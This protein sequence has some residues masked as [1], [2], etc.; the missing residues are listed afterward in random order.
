[1]AAK[2][3]KPA[4]QRSRYDDYEVGKKMR[5]KCS[6]RSHA[7]LGAI[8]KKRDAVQILIDQGKDRLQFLLGLRY[9]RMSTSAFAF[10]RGAAAVMAADLSQTPSSGNLVRACGDAHLGNFGA[11]STPEHR[12]LFDVNDFDE[13]HPGPWEWDLKR[14]AASFVI[15]CQAAGY[16]NTDAEEV[17]R[18]TVKAYNKMCHKLGAMTILDAFASFEDYEELLCLLRDQKLELSAAKAIK[19]A[20]EK[21]KGIVEFQKLAHHVDGKPEIIDRPPG[22]FHPTSAQIP[23]FQTLVKRGIKQYIE[24]LPYARRVLMQRYELADLALKVVGVGSVGTLC[25]VALFFAD[26]DDPLFLQIKEAHASVL[27]KYIK[28]PDYKH[29]SHGERVVRSQLALQAAS[30]RFLGYFVD[31]QTKRHFYVRKL[32]DVKISV[33]YETFKKKAMLEYAKW[34]GW[35]LARAHTRSGDPA[36]IAGYIGENGFEFVDAI[37]EFAFAYSALN[38]SDHQNL[39]NA[40]KSGRVTATEEKKK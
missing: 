30:D 17:V 4:Y 34:C 25:A 39:L 8:S 26:E 20:R 22:I 6:H 23:G 2:A 24:S 32:W 27:E 12:L 15:A 16:S 35:A 10:Y 14:L 7:K 29:I 18:T 38:K 11:F 37:T 9:A 36:L 3:R 21:A 28:V 40:I 19:S 31:K 1:M 5:D 13:A 33:P